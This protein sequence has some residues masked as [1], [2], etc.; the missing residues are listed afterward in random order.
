MSEPLHQPDESQNCCSKLLHTDKVTAKQGCTWLGSFLNGRLQ[1]TTPSSTAGNTSSKQGLFTP[2]LNHATVTVSCRHCYS[3]A[4]RGQ[5][6]AHVA[7]AWPCMTRSC[8]TTGQTYR[9]ATSEGGRRVTADFHHTC[10]LLLASSLRH[11]LGRHG[12]VWLALL[13]PPAWRHPYDLEVCLLHQYHHHLSLR[14]G[15][16]PGCCLLPGP[17][18]CVCAAAGCLRGCRCLPAAAQASCSSTHN[19]CSWRHHSTHNSPTH[20]RA[21]AAAAHDCKDSHLLPQLQTAT[22]NQA[23][24]LPTAGSQH[25]WQCHRPPTLASGYYC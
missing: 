8:Q 11:Y 1:T 20:R 5:L 19:S 12:L 9:L 24:S 10:L 22:A 4:Q 18:L 25:L 7:P 21:A 15:N 14:W 2:F 17:R 16:P 23:P 6:V 13:D 3:A